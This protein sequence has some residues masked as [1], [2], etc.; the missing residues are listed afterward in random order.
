MNALNRVRARTSLIISIAGVLSLYSQ[1]DLA[2]YDG[3][4]PLIFDAGVGPFFSV[5]EPFVD[6]DGW[7][8]Q[9]EGTE[10][11]RSNVTPTP[12]VGTDESVLDPI[13]EQL[14]LDMT[15]DDR[16]RSANCLRESSQVRSTTCSCYPFAGEPSKSRT[17]TLLAYSFHF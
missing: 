1:S 11:M 9:G 14:Y 6:D 7:H 13:V 15:M 12:R 3:P 2:A 4:F 5:T 17:P 10:R 16:A 8:Y